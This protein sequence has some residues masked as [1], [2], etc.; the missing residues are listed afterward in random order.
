MRPNHITVSRAGSQVGAIIGGIDLSRPM[1]DAEYGT[2]R[3]ALVD[4]GVIFFRDQHLTEDQHI[5]FAGR[6]GAI[7][8]NRFFKAVDGF[9]QIAEVRKEPEQKANIGGGWH[10]DH[11]YDVAPA[12]GSVLYARVVPEVGGDT[13]F[14]NMGAVFDSLSPGMQRTLEGLRAVHSSRHV[15]GAARPKTP[16]EDREGRIGNPE[17]ATQDTTHPV[18]IRHPDSGRRVLYVNPGFTV[19]IEGWHPGE[20]KALLDYLYAQAARPEFQYRFEW[21]K[22][23]LAFWDNRATWHMALNDYHGHRWLM[24][25]ITVEGCP[26][27]S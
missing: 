16:D 26:L 10:T 15:F 5:A 24:H 25:R 13:I 11:S 18:V 21:K 3:Q 1:A 12:L 2:V 17:L 22:G 19:G 8:I 14:V 7:N 4:H 9:P 20:S 23:S 27:T 6:F